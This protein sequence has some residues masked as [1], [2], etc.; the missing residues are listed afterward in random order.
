MANTE[1]YLL[2]QK[3]TPTTDR[4]VLT[5]LSLSPISYFRKITLFHPQQSIVLC[6]TIDGVEL[7][8]S[9]PWPHVTDTYIKYASLV[10]F[11][12]LVVAATRARALENS[13]CDNKIPQS[14]LL[15]R[16]YLAMT[17]TAQKTATLQKSRHFQYIR[18]SSVRCVSVN[19][20]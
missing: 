18:D 1:K 20:P 11:V 4:S 12:N 5:S 8:S 14:P 17:T 15:R 3:S 19:Y 13:S 2:C 7:L 9:S 10:V 16:G 6:S